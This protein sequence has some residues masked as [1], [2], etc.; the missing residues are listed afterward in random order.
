MKA[1]YPLDLVV[2]VADLDQQEV[3]RSLLDKRPESLG[4]RKIRRELLKHP[5]HDPGCFVEA[6]ALLRT[7]Q[8]RA[9]HAVVLLDREGSGKE[10]LSADE[11]ENHLNGRLT[12]SGWGDRART[13]VIDPELE[14]WVWSDSPQVD[15]GLGWSGRTPSLRQWLLTR[16]LWPPGAA[17]P[18]SPKEALHA[19]LRE[20]R[21]RAVASIFSRLAATVSLDRCEDPSFSRLRGFL[22]GWFPS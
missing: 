16:G 13:V 4:I 7:Y 17:K 21:Q 5:R 18:P 11:M 2:L 22:R 1:E 19:A 10:E 9:A 14:I 15:E 6:P 20:V 12:A 8:D 3:M